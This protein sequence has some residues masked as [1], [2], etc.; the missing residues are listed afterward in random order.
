[1]I[2]PIMFNDASFSP[3]EQC[4]T[5]PALWADVMVALTEWHEIFI[6][7]TAAAVLSVAGGA[8]AL[9]GDFGIHTHSASGLL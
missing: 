2:Y 7:G 8:D 6:L 5:K 4:T 9:V 1:M 3:A